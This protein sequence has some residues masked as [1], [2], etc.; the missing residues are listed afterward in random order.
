MFDQK[1]TCLECRGEGVVEHPF[2]QGGYASSHAEC[3][4]DPPLIDCEHCDGSGECD[5]EDCVNTAAENAWS[6]R[7]ES[8]PPITAQERLEAA[9]REKQELRR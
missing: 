9:W 3:P 7:C 6:D 5:C 2:L 8:E 4:Q 1:A